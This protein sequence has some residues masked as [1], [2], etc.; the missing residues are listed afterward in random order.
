[1]R[2]PTRHPHKKQRFSPHPV[3]WRH[4]LLY[5][6]CDACA[7]P[8]TPTGPLFS[9]RVSHMDY[10]LFNYK[11]KYGYSKDATLLSRG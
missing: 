6:V 9:L 7:L 10:G 1:M 5:P 4:V 8:P 3:V 11:L 2:G